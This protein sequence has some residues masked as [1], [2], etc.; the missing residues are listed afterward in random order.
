MANKNAAEHGGSDVDLDRELE[1]AAA[2]VSTD[3]LICEKPLRCF[4][5]EV[6]GGLTP[7]GKAF[8]DAY[9]VSCNC[10]HSPDDGT[11][12]RHYQHLSVRQNQDAVAAS[13]DADEYVTVL[14]DRP[15]R[16]T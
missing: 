16:L 9:C 3:V 2:N 5:C 14:G 6:R 4:F 8:L 10:E 1:R 12:R 13:G 15:R 7:D 11:V